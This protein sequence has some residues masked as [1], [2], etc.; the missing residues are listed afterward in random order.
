MELPNK[1]KIINDKLTEIFGTN[2]YGK[3]IYKI[4]FSDNEREYRTGIFNEFYGS[5]F[6]RTLT[7]T[8]FRKKYPWIKSKFIIEKWI[9]PDKIYS[10]EIPDSIN[11]SYEV[12]YVFED[13]ERNYLEPIERVSIIVCHANQNPMNF[14]ELK[15]FLDE[16]QNKSEKLEYDLVY[17]GMD[18]TPTSLAL[19]TGEGIIVPGD[20]K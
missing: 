15:E 4:S 12:I 18:T 13:M 10:K 1:V 2:L 19:A 17:Y 3:P 20:I 9:A 8:Q 6:I 5:I 14:W 16:Y 7:G 11:G